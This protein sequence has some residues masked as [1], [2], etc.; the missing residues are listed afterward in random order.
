MHWRCQGPGWT[1][2]VFYLHWWPKCKLEVPGATAARTG[3]AVWGCSTDCGRK[4]WSPHFTSHMSNST[5]AGQIRNK[6]VKLPVLLLLIFFWLSA[7]WPSIFS[8]AIFLLVPRGAN[9]VGELLL[10]SA[11]CAS[12]VLLRLPHSASKLAAPHQARHRYNIDFTRFQRI[13]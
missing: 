7:D 2:A 11:Q 4:L 1:S 3:R 10:L 5:P 12:G 9:V 13:R 8:P 6:K